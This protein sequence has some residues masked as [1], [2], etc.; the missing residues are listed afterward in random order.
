VAVR[1][2]LYSALEAA[3]NDPQVVKMAASS[4][5]EEGLMTGDEFRAFLEGDIVMWTDVIKHA[6][7]PLDQKPQD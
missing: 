1:N 5:L 7:L 4:G 6:K 2:R 3:V